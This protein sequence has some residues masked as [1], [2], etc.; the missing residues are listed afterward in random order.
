LQKWESEAKENIIINTPQIFHHVPNAPEH[1]F[2]GRYELHKR[3]KEKLT[4]DK[5]K[6]TLA[7]VGPAGIGKSTLAI[8]LAHNEEIQDHFYY[9]IIWIGLG[10][11]PS[12]SQKLSELCIELGVSQKDLANL[13]SIE[14]LGRK[15]QQLIAGRRILIIIDDAWRIN[16]ALA[17]KIGGRNCFYLITTRSPKL[18][19]EFAPENYEL[20]TELDDVNKL[21]L[22][23]LLAPKAYEAAIN[24]FEQLISQASGIPLDIEIIGKTLHVA[25]EIGGRSRLIRQIEL[26]SDTRERLKSEIVISPYELTLS[27]I[28]EDTNKSIYRSLSKSYSF[29]DGSSQKA[30]QSLSVFPPQP[31][32][33]SEQAALAIIHWG[34]KSFE[35]L[36]DI[37]LIT[38]S[39]NDRYAFHQLNHEFVKTQINIKLP[40]EDLISYYIGK[41]FDYSIHFKELKEDIENIQ[42]AFQ[43][44][45]DN[46][47][48]NSIVDLINIYYQFLESVG[49]YDKAKNYLSQAEELSFK[50]NDETRLI[51]TLVNKGRLQKTL[52]KFQEAEGIFHQALKILR[53]I[54]DRP[55]LR[56]KALEGLGVSIVNQEGRIAEAQSFLTEGLEIARD[57]NLKPELCNMLQNLSSINVIHG[58]YAQA[59]HYLDEAISIAD[60]IGYLQT[61]CYMLINQGAIASELGDLESAEAYITESVNTSRYLG[62]QHMIAHTL[63]QLGG[64][65]NLQKE[66]HSALDY[67]YEA[68]S[69]AE[70][71]SNSQL[72]IATSRNIGTAEG[73]LENIEKSDKYFS[74]SLEIAHG[75]HHSY[76][77]GTILCDW[78]EVLL[79][80]SDESKSKDYFHET[81]RIASELEDKEL[82]ATGKYGL[83][84]CAELRGDYVLARSLG[85]E[86]LSIYDA[87]KHRRSNEVR[88]WIAGLPKM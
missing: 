55:D 45:T 61:K 60:E 23:T 1:A 84:R 82:I 29:L 73:Y 74:Q 59:L 81:V 75:L 37:G 17:F 31:N 25:F 33:F 62:H 16:D 86:S 71:L 72:I 9:G 5:A 83:G 2:I 85:Y 13:N 64:V 24:E 28:S 39:S 40:Y 7:I 70:N 27:R 69:L 49:Q 76:Y 43:H 35:L 41:S 53:R 30:L 44:A 38:R 42:V 78:G 50:I 4:S 12:I 19:V 56:C 65:K 10:P 22:A 80:R 57:Q 88:K 54:T 21:D 3:L 51:E 11:K 48:D 47:L 14:D 8:K 87:L 15:I 68:L 63:T 36:V 20:L 58:N 52:G 6:T 66:Y 79:L 46:K 32:T 67:L 77:I 34:V 18:G 26:M